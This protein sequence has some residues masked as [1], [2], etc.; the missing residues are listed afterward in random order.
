MSPHEE[1][2]ATLKVGDKVAVNTR[3]LG[4]FYGRNHGPEV[5]VVTNITPSRARFDLTHPDSRKTSCGRGGIHHLFGMNEITDA[6]LREIDGD[7][8]FL[9]LAN[10]IG[11][12]ETFFHDLNRLEDRR[13]VMREADLQ[14]YTVTMEQLA[15]N[16]VDGLA[17]AKAT[18][19]KRMGG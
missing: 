6:V 8:K 11:K 2:I 5:W 18:R 17:A 7:E 10:A 4:F 14:F 9:R 13:L 16:L 19:K 3:D 1:F 12:L 15:K